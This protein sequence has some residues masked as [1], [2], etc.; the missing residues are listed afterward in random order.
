MQKPAEMNFD[1]C[2][3]VCV[4]ESFSNF[5]HFFDNRLPKILYRT[6]KDMDKKMYTDTCI[7]H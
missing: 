6:T 1:S 7:I 3:G 5:E 4:H 2:T